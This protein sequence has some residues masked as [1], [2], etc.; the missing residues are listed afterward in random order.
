MLIQKENINNYRMLSLIQALKLEIL[1]MKKSGTSAYKM[2]KVEYNL[3]GS[4]QSVLEQM[5]AIKSEVNLWEAGA[6]FASLW[7]WIVGS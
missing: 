5:Q 4:K 3:K 2:L 7:R 1:G 6:I